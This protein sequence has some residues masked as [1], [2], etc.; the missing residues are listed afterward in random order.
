MVKYVVALLRIT[1]AQVDY[2]S[3]WRDGREKLGRREGRIRMRI[4]SAVNV[5]GGNKIELHT[6]DS[7]TYSAVRAIS[8]VSKQRYG[9]QSKHVW[10]R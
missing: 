9:G 7:W 3:E 4:Q 5:Y 6:A 10:M 1:K 2:A 8:I